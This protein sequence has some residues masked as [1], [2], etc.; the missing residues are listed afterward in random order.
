[1]VR[2]N[3]TFQAKGDLKNIA[4]YISK[5]S[6]LYAKLQITRLKTRTRIL[7]TQPRSGKIVPEINIDNIRELTEGSCRIIYKIVENNQIDI[8]TIHHSARDLTR[9]KTE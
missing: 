4:E 6:K 9:R 2:I 1:M 8:L 3:W 7:K 5:D